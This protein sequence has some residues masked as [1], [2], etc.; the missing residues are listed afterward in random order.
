MRGLVSVNIRPARWTSRSLLIAVAAA[1]SLSF[2]APALAQETDSGGVPTAAQV[3]AKDLERLVT[4]LEDEEARADLVRQLRAMIAAER[5]LQ[6]SQEPETVGGSVLARLSEQVRRASQDI[7]DAA[8][9]V[10]D[11]P[12]FFDWFRTQVSERK[13][14]AQFL[15]ELI[16]FVGIILVALLGER[17]TTAAL[18]RPR[19]AIEERETDTVPVRI[20][21]LLGR[22]VLD[23][24]P[25]AAFA[26]VGY[27]LLP[28]AEPV[29]A[30]RVMTLAIINASV[31]ARALM[32]VARML[33][34]PKVRS[35]RLMPLGD[36]PA[37]YVYLWARR[38]T[39]VGVYG[40]LL[41]GVAP[42]LGLPRGTDLF[43]VNIVGLILAIMLVIL[44][45]QNRITVA[46]WI[47]GSGGDDARPSLVSLRDRLG[48]VWH[49]L[50]IIY[51]VGIYAV[52]ALQIEGG[53][54]FVSRA[55]VLTVVILAFAPLIVYA[56]RRLVR[57]GFWLTDELRLRFPTLEARANRYL[58]VFHTILRVV[59]YMFAALG[60]LQA[61]G[62]DAAGWLATETGRE[63]LSSVLTIAIILVLAFVIW[64]AVGSVVEYYLTKA[65]AADTSPARQTKL[66]TFLPLLR[67][68][69]T[70]VLSVLVVLTVLSELGIDIAPL[71]AGAGVLGLAIGFG[72]QTLVKD[73]ITGIF[74]LLE[75]TIA[76][77]DVVTAGGHSGLVETISIRTIRL[78]DLEGTVH[79]VPFSE[80]T[81][82]VNMTKDF[83]FAQIDVG[84]AYR[85][86]VD[87]VIEVLRQIGAELQTDEVYGVEILDSLEVLGLDQFADSAVIIRIRIKTK[88]IKQWMIKREFNRRIKRR[89]DELGI[90]IPFPHTTIYFGEDKLGT[91]PAARVEL[92]RTGGRMKGAQPPDIQPE[93]AQDRDRPMQAPRAADQRRGSL[94]LTE[95]ADGE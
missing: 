53:F 27:G 82:V 45:L 94:L 65:H 5:E 18:R 70:V 89:F 77:G 42:L 24:T 75:D 28:L 50:A 7:V 54:E 30:T 35:L 87:E 92:D 67:R 36:E 16:K 81:T 8:T 57:R 56:G 20:T 74:I 17:L 62:I 43:L 79:T 40:Y 66:L 91:A 59:V 73:I 26:A 68:A 93:A 2:A 15:E 14:R 47:R 51:V 21:F 64:E 1:L 85:E 86:D 84:V 61:W 49:V 33:L 19:R 6:V 13:F 46:S 4:T 22:T 29:D 95:D 71:L 52:W 44:T 78:R 10:L 55:S 90:E 88:P 72:A 58:S 3:P 32:A 31:L 60:I 25:I 76:V 9:V 37:N 63:A 83:S 23:L 34:A 80:V 48:D 41:A 69:L 12:A 11:I 38:L 39:N